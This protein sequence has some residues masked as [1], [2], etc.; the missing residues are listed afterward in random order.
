M[1]LP[2]YADTQL[3]LEKHMKITLQEIKDIFAGSFKEDMEDWQVYVNIHKVG[4]YKVWGLVGTSYQGDHLTCWLV[5][6]CQQGDKHISK[7]KNGK[8]LLN[9]NYLKKKLLKKLLL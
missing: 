2:I 7:F 3:F 6:H 5:Q 1:N 4:L 9:L 8:I